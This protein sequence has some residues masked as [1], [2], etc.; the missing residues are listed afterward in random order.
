MPLSTALAKRET[1]TKVSVVRPSEYRVVLDYSGNK[2][3]K[4]HRFNQRQISIFFTFQSPLMSPFQIAWRGLRDCHE[5]EDLALRSYS[6]GLTDIF[7][8]NPNLI[9]PLEAAILH[10]QF[11][12]YPRSLLVLRYSVGFE[13]GISSPPSLPERH[14]NQAN[15]DNADS[16]ADYR[17]DAHMRRPSGGNPLRF[18]VVFVALALA[19]GFICVGSALRTLTSGKRGAALQLYCATICIAFGVV[20]GRLLIG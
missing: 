13:P 1:E 7:T 12:H 8:F 10:I 20:I 9:V 5:S 14:K 15:A 4:V 11:R 3:L 19:A 6:W 16:H 18:E 17:R 2:A